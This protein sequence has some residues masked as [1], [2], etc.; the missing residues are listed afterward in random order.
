LNPF[1]SRFRQHGQRGVL[2]A[3]L[4]QIGQNLEEVGDVDLN[5][6]HQL[7]EYYDTFWLEEKNLEEKRLAY[8]R[9]SKDSLLNSTNN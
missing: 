6:L 8:L 9:G 2:N 7:I 1:F 3:E 5:D 4:H